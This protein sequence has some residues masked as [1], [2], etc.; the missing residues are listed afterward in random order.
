MVTRQN[1]IF[2]SENLRTIVAM[3]LILCTE[4]GHKNTFKSGVKHFLWIQKY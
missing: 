3:H 1:V 4:L 2:D